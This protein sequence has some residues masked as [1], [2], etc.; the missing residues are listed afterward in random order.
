MPNDTREESSANV[1]VVAWRSIYRVIFAL[2]ATAVLLWVLWQIR[3]LVG[4]IVIS[5]FLSLALEPGVRWLNQRYQWR[6][7]AAVG[8][9]YAAGLAFLIVMVVVLIPAL[10]EFANEVGASG[11]EWVTQLNGWSTDTFGVVVIDPEV[12]TKGSE[13][14]L[15][16]VSDWAEE[17]F[18]GISGIASAGAT[19]VFSLSTIAMFTF[20]FVA[21]SRRIT[22]TFLSWFRPATQ[23]RLGWTLDEAIV[24][25][26]GYFYS[27]TLLMIISA[28][29]FFITM[30][31]VGVPASL[32]LPLAVFG[33][34]VSVFIP[35]IGTY[36]GA[37]IPILVTL[38]VEGLGA[39][40]ILLGYVLVYQLLENSWLS[41]KLSAKTMS[42]SGGL[43]FASALAGGALAGPVGAFLALPTAALISSLI[44][45][46]AKTYKVVYSAAEGGSDTRE[47]NE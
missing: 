36:L 35:V 26:G 37:A 19:L 5:I 24:Q 32:S 39:A 33:G 29:G 11:P 9:M 17:E 43:A 16:Y 45:N 27:R 3:P 46:Y 1:G 14:T 10:T 30:V 41:P 4:M 47:Q 18:G 15:V 13:T 40:V 21:D 8:A 22:N 44:T 20:Y 7:G 34:F 28:A 42:L 6:R 38:A 31:L 25:T 23:H 2:L 12:A